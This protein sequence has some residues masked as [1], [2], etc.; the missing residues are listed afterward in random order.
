MSDHASTARAEIPA[1]SPVWG[2]D[3]AR[4]DVKPHIFEA[5]R[6][7]PDSG[8]LG[9]AGGI[10]ASL[11][12]GSLGLDQGKQCPPRWDRVSRPPFMRRES[13]P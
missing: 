3:A 7:V 1:W 13:S 2:N 10:S 5:S 9:I 8:W 12:A 11:V 4:V 6:M